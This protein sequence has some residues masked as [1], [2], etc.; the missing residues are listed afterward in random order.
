MSKFQM[1]FFCG[2][3]QDL[4]VNYAFG[5]EYTGSPAHCSVCLSL[6][7]KD[8]VGIFEVTDQY[9][10]HDIMFNDHIWYT[11]RWVT[12][13]KR[14]LHGLYKPEIAARVA[15]AK[16]GVLNVHSYRTA[17]LDSYPPGFLQ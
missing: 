11:G 4:P 5:G 14:F 17:R 10:G 12:V 9:P 13:G 1:C 3:N 16:A 15:E 6:I 8:Q 2:G 7:G